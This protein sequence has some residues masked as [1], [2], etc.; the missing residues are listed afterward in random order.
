MVGSSALLLTLLLPGAAAF[1]P[2]P[3]AP[4]SVNTPRHQSASALEVADEEVD[5]A[6]DPYDSYRATDDQRE[7]AL[8]DTKIGSGYTVGEV[9]NQLLQ[10]KYTAKFVDG[11]FTANIREF[12]VE[13]SVF[14]MGEQRILPGLEEGITGMKVGGTRKVKVPPNR[15]YGD[16]WYRGI[17]PP[18]SHLEFDCELLT[19]AQSPGEEFMMKLEQFGYARAAGATFCFA[20]L[21]ASP[22]LGPH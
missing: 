20:Y 19:I 7:I 1:A 13:S 5:I 17:V 9:E 6:A 8:K 12:D 14:Q 16:S 2:T 21:A 18:N 4:W 10:L 3:L 11:K 22:F 15:G